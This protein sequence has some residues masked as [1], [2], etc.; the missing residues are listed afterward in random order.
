[1]TRTLGRQNRRFRPLRGSSV[2]AAAL[3]QLREREL[4]RLRTQE[5]R[6]RKAQERRRRK[7]QERLLR[8]TLGTRRR[9]T[10]KRLL[11]NHATGTHGPGHGC[12]G[13]SRDQAASLAL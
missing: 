2:R 5:R 11:S 3:R 13:K 1:M 8:R 12:G 9:K 4:R 6:R 10:P 7:A